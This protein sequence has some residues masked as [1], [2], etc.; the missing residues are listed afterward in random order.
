M[1]L[2]GTGAGDTG[3]VLAGGGVMMDVSVEGEGSSGFSGG[4]SGDPGQT[5]AVV[6]GGGAAEVGSSGGHSGE[7]GQTGS[8]GSSGVSEVVGVTME[9]VMA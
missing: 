5:G 3:V 9:V 1:P 8:V 2:V 6:L 7:P 4:H